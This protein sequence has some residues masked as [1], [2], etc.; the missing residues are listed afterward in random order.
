[1]T[2]SGRSPWHVPAVLALLAIAAIFV[3]SSGCTQQA[4][5]AQG[6][7]ATLQTTAAP[8]TPATATPAQEGKK[9]VT[10]TEKD[11]G[12]TA[13][14]AATTRFAVQLEENPTTGYSWNASTS[15]GLTVLSSDY[16]E[17]KHAEGMVGV[18]GIRTWVLQAAGSGDQAF[19]ATYRRSWE[20]V[21]GN[22]TGYSVG[23]RIVTT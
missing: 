14:I 8:G 11:N 5:P 18:G 19:N 23:I 1:M 21:T 3:L 15:S 9:M 16:Q 22:E 4:T 10:F 17:N 13:D 12:T 7:I 2:P 20:P 6:S